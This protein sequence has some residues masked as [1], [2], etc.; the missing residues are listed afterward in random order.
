MLLH[1]TYIENNGSEIMTKILQLDQ[2][3]PDAY[4]L[5]FNTLFGQ[6]RELS[7]Q[8]CRTPCEQC[9]S[10]LG[11]GTM[12]SKIC[13]LINTFVSYETYSLMS[14][15]TFQEINTGNYSSAVDGK[16]NGLQCMQYSGDQYDNS[17]VCFTYVY[18][19]SNDE[20]YCNITYN[21][22]LCNSC[23]I[24]SNGCFSAD[25]TNVDTTYGTMIDLCQKVGLSG[26]FQ[27]FNAFAEADNTTYTAGT[28]DIDAPAPVAPM[29]GPA[30]S[31]TPLTPNA[32]PTSDSN[33]NASTL[34]L[35][36]VAIVTSIVMFRNLS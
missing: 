12:T 25:C 26:P 11:N 31:P 10:P 22:V 19:L 21:D 24:S 28:C 35:S 16:Y 17:K 36:V 23:T 13:G 4:V 33:C 2:T 1:A 20:N 18:L 29:K 32:A 8:T 7:N 30:A 9:Y 5:A 15:F 27:I 3:D 14:N 34:S 6:Q